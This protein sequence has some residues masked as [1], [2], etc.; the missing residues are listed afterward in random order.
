MRY[1]ARIRP[2]S[3]FASRSL[4]NLQRVL[5]ALALED[6][7]A[8]AELVGGAVGEHGVEPDVLLLRGER[9]RGDAQ[10][11]LLRHRRLVQLHHLERQR[12]RHLLRRQLRQGQH[13]R[14]GRRGWKWNEM[15]K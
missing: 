14:R 8:L 1:F 5:D 7:L 9:P 13:R 6:V 15:G 10:L 12:R 11:Q 4:T 3:P 2:S